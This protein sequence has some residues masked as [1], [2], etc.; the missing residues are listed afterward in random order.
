VSWSSRQHGGYKRVAK[1]TGLGLSLCR[2][3]IETLHG[4]EIGLESRLGLGSK[5]W[6]TVPMCLQSGR[7]NERK[8]LAA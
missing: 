4:G 1:G 3:I 5:F 2:Q 7:E 8:A 6:F